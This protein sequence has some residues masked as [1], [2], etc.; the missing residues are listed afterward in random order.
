MSEAIIIIEKILI[1]APGILMG[2]VLHELAH[3]YVAYKCGDPT[4]KN[5]GRLTLNPIKHMD[6]FGTFLLPLSLILFKAPFIF[7]Y[8]KPVPVVFQQLKSPRRDMI[9]V[10]AA[11]PITNFLIALASGLG[12]ALLPKLWV[13]PHPVLILTLTFAMIINVTLGI[14]NLFPLLPLDG[15]RIL[16]GLLPP[17]LAEKFAKTERFGFM[18]LLILIVLLP[19]IGRYFSYDINVFRDMIQPIVQRVVNIILDITHI[20]Q[21]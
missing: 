1:Y 21:P 7:G 5:M 16:T 14:F 11:G 18:T 4:A 17:P 3:G 2:V 8:A 12:V 6:L 13:D 10:A 20:S 15:G 9:L 19:V